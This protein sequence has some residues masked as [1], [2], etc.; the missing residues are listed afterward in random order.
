MKLHRIYFFFLGAIF[1]CLVALISC[2]KK[3]AP[4]GGPAKGITPAEAP[5]SGEKTYAVNEGT[6]TQRSDGTPTKGAPNIVFIMG[7]DIG[8]YNPSIYNR[9]DMGYQTPN[10]DRIGKE[11]GMFLSWY[12]QQ[13]CTAGRA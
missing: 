13:S 4:Q 1:L 11:G 9:G 2:A 5:P 6:T 10:I 12:A 3:E 8:W 7:D